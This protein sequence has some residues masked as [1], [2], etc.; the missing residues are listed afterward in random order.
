MWYIRG[1][2]K[3]ILFLFVLAFAFGLFN[4]NSAS[5]SGPYNNYLSGCSSYEGFSSTTGESCY[6]TSPTPTTISPSILLIGG[7][8]ASYS[9]GSTIRLYVRGLDGAKY[10]ASNV[11]GY[12]VQ[13]YIFP[14]S[15]IS[16]SNYLNPDPIDSYN[17]TYNSLGNYWNIK[18][19]APLVSGS[20]NLRVILYCSKIENDCVNYGDPSYHRESVKIL[21]FTVIPDPTIIPNP[22]P[23]ICI[24][25]TSSATPQSTTN[26][27]G[28]IAITSP[29]GG[30]CLTKGSTKTITW[31]SSSNIDKVMIGYS[32][33]VGSLNWITNN[34]L[35][36]NTGSYDWN[37]NIGN[38][39]NTKVKIKITGYQTGTGSVT[40]SS[41]DFFTVSN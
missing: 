28:S 2:K 20:Y 41:D 10:P 8:K 21:P 18:T 5:A 1:M 24:P 36:S 3:Y 15:D 29:N 16:F 19:K 27:V 13:A 6:V 17:G 35:V 31:T 4:I 37:V 38:T 14:S 7:N 33:G 9:K 25:T 26:S 12:N 39:T 32:F 30:E 23:T 11:N 22:T 34:G 40:D